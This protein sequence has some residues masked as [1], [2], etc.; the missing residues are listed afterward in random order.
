MGLYRFK[1]KGP[2]YGLGH[3]EG[4][5]VEYDEKAKIEALCLVPV[6]NKDGN[7]TSKMVVAKKQYT[8]EYLLEMGVI[9]PANDADRKKLKERQDI[10]SL[11]DVRSIKAAAEDKA[12]LEARKALMK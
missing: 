2:A 11:A 5:L 6:V 3:T 4:E 10:N 7:L 8:V 1:E 12:Q 9:T